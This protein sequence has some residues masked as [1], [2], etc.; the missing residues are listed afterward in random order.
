MQIQSLQ[1]YFE[2]GHFYQASGQK[3]VLPELQPVVVSI[4][5]LPD[6]VRFPDKRTE[7]EFWQDFDKL[8]GESFDEEI[9]IEDFP[10]SNFSREIEWF[11]DED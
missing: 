9:S 6:V 4:L 5:A 10:R 7:K 3:Y 8:A 2:N 11:E 1:G